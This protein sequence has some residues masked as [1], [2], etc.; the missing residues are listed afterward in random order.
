MRWI[1][2]ACLSA[3]LAFASAAPARDPAPDFALARA[4]LK[5][6]VEVRTVH[7]D[8]DNTAAA[9]AVE[10]RLLEA[11][12]DPSDVR[13]LEPAP[14]KGNLV[15]RLRGTGEGKPMLLLAHI[16]V[17]EARRD[18][19]SDGIDP[20]TLTE[21]DGWLY[22]RGVLDDKGSAAIFAA[23]LIELRRSGFRP[24]RDVILA[25][26]A[27]EEGGTHNGV[28]WLL[29]QHRDLV[30]AEFAIN[31]GG[32]GGLRHGRP[33]QLGVQ[34]SEKRY[35][36]FELEATNPGGHSS[37]PRPDNAI[38]ELSA[39]LVRIGAMELPARI[40]AVSRAAAALAAER[41]SGARAAAY[42][43]VAKGDPTSEEL[44]QAAT[45]PSMNAQLR[46]TCVAT[47]VDAGHADNALAQRARATVNCRLLPGDGLAFVQAELEKAAG[48]GIKVTPKNALASSPETDVR[49]PVMALIQ[50]EAAARWPGIVAMPVM[51]AGATDGSQLRA[52]GI[53]VFGLLPLF[54]ETS[55]WA[56]MHGRDERIPAKGFREAHEFLGRLVRALAPGP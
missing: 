50:R 24:K 13:V 32:F 42:E 16:D 35:L 46:T 21:R 18:D 26:T 9:R 51:S 36:T 11:G 20:W 8:G 2:G 22:G 33:A 43:A 23:T 25:L 29:R 38:Y 15:A 49:S 19:W 40:G 52:A 30:D 34:V 54:M 17:V 44:R 10:R 31:E 14:L 45:S 4:I 47:R 41:E 27:D 56:R 12:F 55:D 37:L 1:T 5:E 28:A 53:P 6:L 3:A 7:P 48:A 39:A